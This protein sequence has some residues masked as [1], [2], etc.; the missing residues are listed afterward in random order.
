MSNTIVLENSHPQAYD[1]ALAKYLGSIPAAVLF[2]QLNFW[3]GKGA[4]PDGWFWKPSR[5]IEDETGMTEKQIRL[6]IKKL[7]D[8]GFIEA[9][10]MKAYG[11]PTRHFRV[12]LNLE[13]VAK[14]L[15]RAKTSVLPKRA[16]QKRPKGQNEVPQRANDI[17]S[18]TQSITTVLS[19]EKLKEIEAFK[20]RFGFDR[21]R[22]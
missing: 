10:V 12:L 16:F 11:K 4:R 9:K 8:A 7:K 22:A 14:P 19:T 5:A 2:H 21:P 15:K 1:A 6:A 17:Q 3:N 13:L 18:N 20:K